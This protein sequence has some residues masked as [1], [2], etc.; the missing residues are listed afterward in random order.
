MNHYY[1]FEDSLKQLHASQLVAPSYVLW[2]L[3]CSIIPV[4]L[5]GFALG[6]PRA[7]FVEK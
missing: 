4:L 3:L 2:S 7:P 1:Y 5:P 6:S